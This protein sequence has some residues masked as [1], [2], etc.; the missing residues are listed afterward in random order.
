MLCRGVCW[1]W[2]FWVWGFFF[3]VGEE[4]QYIWFGG[5]WFSVAAPVSYR[6]YLSC[7][8][9][10]CIIEIQSS[11]C[12]D[13]EIKAH[14]KWDMPR[15]TEVNGGRTQ[16][17]PPIPAGGFLSVRCCH[18]V[19]IHIWRLQT[20][21]S[22]G[23]LQEGH[24]AAIYSPILCK[25]REGPP[26]PAP[27]PDCTEPQPD[28]GMTAQWLRKARS[29]VTHKRRFESLLWSFLAMCPWTTHL[30]WPSVSPYVKCG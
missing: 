8:F 21:Q 11:V 22:L 27:Q 25:D 17:P 10:L 16:T 14:K 23:S 9:S 19:A 3:S 24:S 26:L 6:W 13:G 28:K 5:I 20:Q 30:L 4:K 15:A 12:E 29:P 1:W 7:K 2:V 18:L